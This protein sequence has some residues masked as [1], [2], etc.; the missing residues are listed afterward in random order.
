MRC[1]RVNDRGQAIGE[2]HH[3]AV[4]TDREVEQLI[5]DRGDE[6]DPAMTYAQL[7]AKYGISK[8][9][10][11]DIL[12]GRRRGQIG[13]KTGKHRK[14][15]AKQKRVRINYVVSLHTRAWL[16]RMGGGAFLERL[17]EELPERAPSAQSLS[18]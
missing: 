2:G 10:V 9:S 4:L 7:M 1:V 14:T 13:P 16:A 18:L 3:K 6:K 5:A 15:L 11:R 8:S 17:R 12:C